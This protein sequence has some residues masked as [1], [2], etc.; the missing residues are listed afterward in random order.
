MG[1][2]STARF[3]ELEVEEEK[4]EV[5]RIDEHCASVLRGEKEGGKRG[6]RAEH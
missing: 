2:V 4:G 1:G 3:G 5:A 6:E